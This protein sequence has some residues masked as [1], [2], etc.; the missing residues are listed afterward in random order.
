MDEVLKNM[1]TQLTTFQ[2]RAKEQDPI[3]AKQKQRFVVGLKQ[4]R[5]CASVLIFHGH[6][7]TMKMLNESD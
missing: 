1:L 2:N 6:A 4:V 5:I 3:K 7:L